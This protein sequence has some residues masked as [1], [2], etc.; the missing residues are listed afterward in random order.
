[1][2]LI[3]GQNQAFLFHEYPKHY[4]GGRK[5]KDENQDKIYET[6]HFN[7]VDIIYIYITF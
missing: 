4:S 7:A 6:N 1:M 3:N 5:V 2:G